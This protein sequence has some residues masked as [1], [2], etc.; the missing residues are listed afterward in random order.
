MKGHCI[1][2]ASLQELLSKD[3]KMF[4]RLFPVIL[5][6][7][8]QLFIFSEN[9]V[10]IYVNVIS[11]WLIYKAPEGSTSGEFPPYNILNMKSKSTIPSAS[12]YELY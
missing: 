5:K 10:F 1:S 6:K 3:N 4:E 2:S 8:L 12:G 11:M 9:Y 7:M